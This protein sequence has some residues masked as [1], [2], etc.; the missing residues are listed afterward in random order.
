[1][2][3]DEQEDG[4][5]TNRSQRKKIKKRKINKMEKE[6]KK[7]KRN[8]SM[9]EDKEDKKRDK[10]EYGMMIMMMTRKM[11]ILENINLDQRKDKCFDPGVT[12][13]GRVR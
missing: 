6:D 13:P 1:M 4:R 9:E 5:T 7:E 2:E 11:I 3:K 12:Q 8:K 10:Q